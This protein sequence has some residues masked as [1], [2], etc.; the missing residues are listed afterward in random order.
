[1]TRPHV[2]DYAGAG[3]RLAPA[4]G[5][6]LP[7]ASWQHDDDTFWIATRGPAGG[8]A[9]EL[10]AFASARPRGDTLELKIRVYKGSGGVC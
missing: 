2:L 4:R 7:A 6:A 1:M 8:R 10:L 9:G 5:L 3:A